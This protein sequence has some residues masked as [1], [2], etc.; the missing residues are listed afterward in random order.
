MS[1]FPRHLQN[2]FEEPTRAWKLNQAFILDI[3]SSHVVH[4][5]REAG[6]LREACVAQWIE[7]PSTEQRVRGSTL[8][9]S[10]YDSKIEASVVCDH[11]SLLF[12]DTGWCS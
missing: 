9:E 6:S 4:S 1:T 5:K 8:V 3:E 10:Q 2:N 11:A 7:R 12:P